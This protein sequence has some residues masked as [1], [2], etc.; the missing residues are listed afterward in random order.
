MGK[1]A[2]VIVKNA[3]ML[4]IGGVIA[5][6]AKKGIDKFVYPEAERYTRGAAEIRK[7]IKHID[8]NWLAGVVKVKTWDYP[9]IA[10]VETY[11][12]QTEVTDQESLYYLVDNNR[13]YLKFCSSGNLI[14][15]KRKELTLC[16]PNEVVIDDIKIHTTSSDVEVYDTVVDDV[17]ITTNSG[18]VFADIPSSDIVEIK[19]TSGNVEI[20]VSSLGSMDIKTVSGNVGAYSDVLPSNLNVKTSSG[21]VT[22]KLPAYAKFYPEVATTS[23][24]VYSEFRYEESNEKIAVKTV[25]GNINFIMK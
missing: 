9:T 11:P 25:S 2:S 17:L 8:I 10:F 5:T 3:A 24:S 22:V 21:E 1:L 7:E 23:G 15:L 6:L 4:A 12:N 18:T 19:T 13:L 20:N 16:I 14:N